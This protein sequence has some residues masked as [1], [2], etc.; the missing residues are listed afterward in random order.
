MK[1]TSL[2]RGVR[3]IAE[4]G[5]RGR[6]ENV[7]HFVR[8][9]GCLC[10][11]LLGVIHR[12]LIQADLR[13]MNPDADRARSA[14]GVVPITPLNAVSVKVSGRSRRVADPAAPPPTLA[15]LRDAPRL[16]HDVLRTEQAYADRALRR[17]S[18]VDRGAASNRPYARL[19]PRAR[20][21]AW[22]RSRCLAIRAA[23]SSGTSGLA[24]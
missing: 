2:S 19:S 24:R 21:G 23:S 20:R 15:R 17:C 3:W 7:H 12:G 9:S 18:S 16:R 5:H 6:V 13:R 1:G 11:T 14:V 8:R 22:A 4:Y 10:E